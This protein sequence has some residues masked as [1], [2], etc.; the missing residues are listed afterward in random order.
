MSKAFHNSI[1]LI[2]FLT[3]LCYNLSIKVWTKVYYLTQE[4]LVEFLTQV[5]LLFIPLVHD[6]YALY[7]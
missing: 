4:N 2:K 6:L 5:Y 1:F 3:I 7:I